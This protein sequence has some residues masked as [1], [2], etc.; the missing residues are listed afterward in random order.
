MGQFR[1]YLI[2]FVFSVSFCAIHTVMSLGS[3][4][5]TA[6]FSSILLLTS[7]DSQ[8][9]C[10]SGQAWFKW[11]CQAS[12]FLHIHGTATTTQAVHIVGLRF[13]KW[14]SESSTSSR[15]GQEASS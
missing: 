4:R 15:K 7:A 2:H 12:N 8:L 11:Q 3:I 1:S 14:D 10:M 6:R 13:F 9:V 5:L